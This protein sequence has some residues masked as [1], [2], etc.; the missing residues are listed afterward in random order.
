MAAMSTI[1]RKPL[2]REKIA[3]LGLAEPDVVAALTTFTDGSGLIVVSDGFI[4]ILKLFADLLSIW[5]HET[6]GPGW[7]GAFR[8]S[9]AVLGG[10]EDED[11]LPALTVALRWNRSS[12]S[13]E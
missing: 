3:T 12:A 2:P 11:L 13:W 4:G 8:L 7:R 10:R 6:G 5:F 1:T 9:R